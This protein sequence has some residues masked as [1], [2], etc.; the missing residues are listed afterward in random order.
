VVEHNPDT[1]EAVVSVKYQDTTMYELCCRVWP[2]VCFH[3]A[4]RQPG[5]NRACC[6]EPLHACTN[7]QKRSDTFCE[8]VYAKALKVAGGSTVCALLSM[9]GARMRVF[10]YW[11][12]PA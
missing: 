12:V 9:P 4:G 3:G 2:F 6:A 7:R 1:A 8:D 10:L 11:Q 5:C